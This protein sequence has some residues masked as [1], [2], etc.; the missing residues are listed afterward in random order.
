VVKHLGLE[1]IGG[2]LHVGEVHYNTE[3]EIDFL[4]SHLDDS[5]KKIY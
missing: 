5:T 3:G 4:L 1:D 2:L